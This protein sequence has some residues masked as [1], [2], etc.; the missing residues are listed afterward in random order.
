MGKPGTGELDKRAKL[1][2]IL[3]TFFIEDELRSLCFE[4]GVDY[5]SLPASGTFGK[6]RELIMRCERNGR[7]GRLQERIKAERPFVEI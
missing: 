7:V 2:N 6:A 3:E 1:L 4:V 5:D